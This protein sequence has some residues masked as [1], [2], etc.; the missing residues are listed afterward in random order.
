MRY[1]VYSYPDRRVTAM[2][3]TVRKFLDTLVAERPPLE[4]CADDIAGAFEL[5]ASCFRA[6]GKLLACGNGGSAADA[7]HVV[8][9][10]MKE[11]LRKRP[12]P[13]A[14]AQRIRAAAPEKGEELCR[15]LQGALRAVSLVSETSLLTAFA[16]DVNADMVFAQQVYGYG[17]PGDVLLAISTSGSSENIINAVCV[18]R[19][20]G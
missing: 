15:G 13:E 16:N 12:V 14:D 10:L 1:A 3:D 19:A 2:R 18:A 11:Y 20:F 5:M 6:G 17:R 8:G 7:Q 4:A 9:E